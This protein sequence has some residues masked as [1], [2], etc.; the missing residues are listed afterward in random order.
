[1][2]WPEMT[3]HDQIWH[4]NYESLIEY[5]QICFKLSKLLHIWSCYVRKNK[6][7][8]MQSCFRITH[9]CSKGKC[10]QIFLGKKKRLI[11]LFCCSMHILDHL[12]Q[13]YKDMIWSCSNIIILWIQSWIFCSVKTALHVM[14]SWVGLGL[15][16]SWDFIEMGWPPPPLKSTW[17]F[18][19]LGI[20]WSGMTP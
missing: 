12:H 3:W 16:W 1:M 11:F 14:W 6:I 5:D 17:D 13:S 18:F 19:E 7:L 2:A 8:Q 9:Y 15:F 4:W 10:K 20:F